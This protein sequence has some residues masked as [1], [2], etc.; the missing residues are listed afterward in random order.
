MPKIVVVTGAESTGKSE[1]TQWLAGKFDAPYIPEYAREYIQNLN[2]KYNYQDVEKIAEIQVKQL[3]SLK[4]CDSSFVFADTWLIITK[5]WFEVVFKKV[6][7]W[8]EDEIRNT[9]IDLFLVCNTDI[10]WQSDPVRE[11]GGKQ[12]LVLQNLYIDNIKAFNF[13]FEMVEGTGTDRFSNALKIIE[14]LKE[15]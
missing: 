11:N 8:L 15:K 13:K 7:V 6:P 2:R 12:R 10:P 5:V 9:P 14:R 1:L 4:N 3:N